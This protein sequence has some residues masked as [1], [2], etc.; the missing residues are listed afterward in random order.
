[1]FPVIDMKNDLVNGYSHYALNDYYYS[2]TARTFGSMCG[3]NGKH[4]EEIELITEVNM[5]SND[6]PRRPPNY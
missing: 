4:Y 6:Y 2:S 5:V 3:E 1:M